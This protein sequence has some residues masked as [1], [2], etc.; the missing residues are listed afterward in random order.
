MSAAE[1]GLQQG[2]QVVR[3]RL[4]RLRHQAAEEQPA[5]ARPASLPQRRPDL[6]VAMA[7]SARLHHGF[8][9][10][11]RARIL[12]PDAPSAAG[13]DLLLVELADQRV[14]GF[15]DAAQ[16]VVVDLLQGAR[17]AQVPVV[18][19]ITGGRPPT[20]RAGV[21]AMTRLLALADHVLVADEAELWGALVDVEVLEPA[22][23]AQRQQRVVEERDGSARRALVVSPG[24]ADP[25]S[26]GPVAVMLGPGLR[27]IA[28]QV[29]ALVLD[30]ELPPRGVLPVPFSEDAAVADAGSLAQALDDAAVYVDVARRT[31]GD[32]W[33]A[34]EA[35]AAGTPVVSVAG[36]PQPAGLTPSA[37]AD[38]A[39]L[40]G[41]V[42]ARLHQ[43]ELGDREAVRARR[44][45]LAQHTYGHRARA[46]LGLVGRPEAEPAVP[47]ISA[48]VPTN[49][50]HELDNVL[51]NIGRQSHPSV[52]LV[53]VLHG[54]SVDEAALRAKA[55]DAGVESLQIVPAASHLTLGACMNLGVDA[56]AGELVAKMDDDNHYGTHYLADLAA[57]MRAQ[58][59]GIAGKWAH[60]VWLRSSGA[61][62]VRYP[63]FEN[64]WVRRIQGGSMLFEGDVVRRVRFGDLPRAVDSDILDRS[65]AEGV[66]IWSADRYN[67]V[68]VRG[69]DRSAHTWTVEDATFLT[70]SGRLAFYGD[71]RPH[72]EV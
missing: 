10:Q 23:P 43:P 9:D 6:T 29:D 34:L 49:R 33:L 67:F 53:L 39:G 50:E 21:E 70:A 37:P 30:P 24:P 45:V 18:V 61:V 35:A 55:A 1:Q 42:V 65:M 14:P 59:A 57:A 38:A 32:T 3:Q 40:R 15:G 19:W 48:V 5:W 41:E 47:S 17:D 58:G 52:E 64:R 51:A 7:T 44:A 69:E 11:W 20:S 12:T 4:R 2:L 22:A 66:S 8:A 31:A 28:A 62:V 71:P 54:I 68:S 16:P 60:H 63:D 27:P 26:A 36:Y 13:A 46:I 56:S 72:V 25:I